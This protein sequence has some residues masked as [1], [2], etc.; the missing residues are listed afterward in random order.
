MVDSLSLN[1]P[2]LTKRYSNENIEPI[3]VRH[4]LDDLYSLNVKY[5]IHICRYD[6]NVDKH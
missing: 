3:L 1:P 6:E 4:H 2:Y 5:S